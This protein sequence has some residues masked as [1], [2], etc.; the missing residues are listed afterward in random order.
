MRKRLALLGILI[1]SILCMFGCNNDPYKNMSIELVGGATTVQ[2]NIEEVTENGQTT[3]TYTPYTFDVAVKNVGDDIDRKVSLS[4]G[5]D[6]VSYSLVYMGDGIT[7]ISVTPLSY[8]KTG[9]FTLTIKTLEGNKV[10]TLDFQIDLKI[11]NFTINQDNL[12]V[13]AKGQSID[14][15][16]IDKYI[17]FF[18]QATTQ[19]NIEFEVVRPEGNVI[20]GHGE[21]NYV[22][23]DE[24]TDTYATIEN[25]VL[26]TFKNVNYPKMV[27]N[28]VVGGSETQVLTPCITLKAHSKDAYNY[29]ENG[30]II[31]QSIPDRFVDIVVIENCENIVL[32]MNCQ[33]ND[34][35]SES[36]N[37]GNSFAL[38]KNKK[39]EYDV[40]LLNPNYRSG[41]MYDSYYIERDLMFDFGSISDDGSYNP[42]DYVVTTS[43]VSEGDARPIALS[44]SSLDNSF[45]VQ[46]QKTGNYSHKFKVD[47]V[48]YPNII[49]TEI[50]VNFHVI[51]IPTDI[52]VNGTVPKD[53]YK[54]YKNYGNSWGT[55]FTVSLINGLDY[56]YFVYVKDQDLGNNL[57]FYKA[58]GSEQ[59]FGLCKEEGGNKVITSMVESSGYSNFN[60][61][62]TFYLRHNFD[63]LP[64]EG[65]QIY[66]GVLFD[67]ASSSYSD[68][69]R[70]DYFI[71]SILEFPLNISF[72]TGLQSLDFTADKYIVDLTNKNY[73][74]ET[75]D[76]TGIKLFDLPAGQTLDN[77]INLDDI[78]YD[79]SLITVYPYMD[80]VENR[81]SFYLK[82]NSEY[83]TGKTTVNFTTKNGIKKSV[84][85]ETIIPTMYAEN[86]NLMDE[87]KMPLSID[88]N[89]GEVL[90][91]FTG[92]S[93]NNPK[94]KFNIYKTGENGQEEWGGYEYTSLQR[95]FM[96]KDTSVNLKFYDYLLTDNDGIKGCT[97]IDITSNIGV[98]FNYP[99]YASY[100]NGKLSV[101]RVTE[102]INNP[103]IMTVSYNGGYIKINDDGSEE[104]VT[105]PVVQEIELYIYLALQGVQVTTA[106]SVDIYINESLGIYSKDLSKHTIRSTFVPRRVELGAQWNNLWFNADLPVSLSYDISKILSSP[107]YLS[108]GNQLIVYS[109]DGSVS[110]EITY[111][112]LF[113]STDMVNYECPIECRIGDSLDEW[114]KTESG[115]GIENYDWF[116]QNRIFNNSIVMV[117]NVYITQFS[118]LQNIN[119]VKFSV[120]Y[121][122]KI[123]NFDLDVA[124]DGVYF[125]KR[126]GKNNEMIANIAYSID[127]TDAV[128]KE[129]MLINGTNDV[130]ST[131]VNSSGI[132]TKGTIKIIGN[133]AGVEYLTAV[134]KDNI[135]S[136]NEN[137]KTYEYYN[138]KLVQ[139]FRVKVADG[140]E[141]YP[142]EI[143]NIDDY[144][145]MQND[146]HNNQYFNYILTTNL[147]LSQIAKPEITFANI[148]EG[149]EDEFNNFSL[150]GNYVYFRNNVLYSFHNSLNNLHIKKTLNNLT[151]EVNIGLFTNINQ[152][153]T[154]KNLSINNAKIEV[155]INALNGQNVNI[156]IIAGNAFNSK[157]NNCAVNG[158]IKIYNYSADTNKS[159]IN[160]GGMIGQTQEVVDIKGLPSAYLEG[161]SNN[162]YNANV[163]VDYM[164]LENELNGVQNALNNHYLNVGGVVGL[165]SGSSYST[166]ED[167]KVLPTIIGIN[168]NSSVGGV[169]GHTK[170]ANINRV[171]VYP[172]I[173][174][175][176]KAQD[177]DNEL[178]ISTFVGSG[179][180]DNTSVQ[181]IKIT[182]SKVYF[183][184]EAYKTWNNNLNVIIKTDSKL[185]FGGI[186]ANLNQN[187]AQIQYTYIRSFHSEDL[188]EEYYANIYITATNGAII[189]GV[190]GKANNNNLLINSSYFNADIMVNGSNHEGQ[191]STNNTIG[192]ILGTSAGVGA[193]SGIS[194]SY[195]IGRVVVEYTEESSIDRA[196]IKGLY[197]NVGLVG[198]VNLVTADAS[199]LSNLIKVN[200]EIKSSSVS[201]L[202]IIENV[203]GVVNSNVYYFGKSNEIIG[204]YKEGSYLVGNN[205]I[206]NSALGASFGENELGQLFKIIGYDIVMDSDNAVATSTSKWI[207]NESANMVGTL[208]FPILLDS[209]KT[210]ALYDLIPE[211]I[212]IDRIAT[213][214]PGIYDVSYTKIVN[215][216]E[217]EVPQIIAFVNKN[218]RGNNN[219]Y[220]DIALNSDKSTVSIRFDGKEIHTSFL[221]INGDMTISEDSYGSVLMLQGFKVYPVGEGIATITLTSVL[222]KTV[223]LNITIKVITGI[224][225]VELI[226]DK[227]VETIGENEF[228]KPI[229]YIDEVINVNLHNINNIDGVSY[230]STYNYGYKLEIVDTI[231]NGKISINGKDF[232]Y[233]LDANENIYI[234]NTTS[235]TIKGVEVGS[236]K[237]R[238]YP[239]VYLEGLE[240]NEEDNHYIVLDNISK[241]FEIVCLARAKSITLNKDELKIA[242]R[243]TTNFRMIVETSNINIKEIIADDGITKSYKISIF[244][245]I[246]LNIRNNKYSIIFSENIAG[247]ETPIEYDATLNAD[248]SYHISSFGFEIKH[249]LIKLQFSGINVSKTE[250]D[251]ISNQNT[252]NLT[253]DVVVTF[254]KDY[255]RQNA[256]DFDLN[257]LFYDCTFKPSSNTLLEDSIRISISP[258]VLSNIFTNYY[259]RGELLVNSENESYP[260]ENEGLF[261]IPGTAGLLKIT[262]DE[263]FNDSSYVT[264]TIDNSYKE[265]VTLSQM[266]GVTN[267]IEVKTSPDDKDIVEYIESYKD[268]RFREEIENTNNYG[269]RLSKLSLNYNELGYFSKTYFVKL[270]LTR[271]YGNLTNIPLTITSYKVDNTGIHKNL[272]KTV[273]YTITQLPLI[274]IKVDNSYSAV[275]GRGV[276]KELEVSVR[277]ITKDIDFSGLSSTMMIVD[278]TNNQVNNLS[279]DYI[280]SGRKYYI[281]ADV[282]SDL[283]SES[284]ISI[285]FKTEE[286]VWGVRETTSTNLRIQIVEYEIESID[287]ERAI[288]GVVTLKHGENLILNTNITYKDI[289]VGNPDKISEYKKLLRNGMGSGIIDLAEYASAGVT[290]VD[291]SN[292]QNVYDGKLRL[293]YGSFDGVSRVYTPMKLGNKY[294][295]ISLGEGNTKTNDEKYRLHYFII[296]GTGI[297]NN[298]NALLRLSIPYIY[299]NGKLQVTDTILGYSI[300][301]VDF[302][303]VVEDSS[304]FDRPNPIETQNDLI[305]A[306]N[307]GGGDYILLNNLELENWTPLDATFNSLDGNGYVI[308]VKS[309]NLSII[310][311]QDSANIGIFGNVSSTTL[312]KN[313][314]I[315]VSSMLITEEEMLQRLDTVSN[316]SKETYL[317]DASIDLSFVNNVTFGILAGTNEGAI[318]NAKV[319][320]STNTYSSLPS[321]KMYYHIVT[322]QGYLSNN[323]VVSKIGGLVG[324][325]AE[326]G[327][328]TNSIIGLNESTMSGNN[329]T[330][331]VVKNPSDSSYNNESDELESLNIYPFVIAGGNNIAGIVAENNGTI[332]NSYVKGVGLYNTYPAVQNSATGGLVATNTGTISSSHVES[333]NITKYRAEEDKF[334]IESTGNIGGLVYSNTGKIENAYSNVYLETQSA[335]TGGFVFTNGESGTI[336]NA[337][338]TSVN[339][340]NLARGQFTGVGANGRDVL[341]SGEYYN[342]YYLVL[343]DENVN[344]LEYAKPIQIE[345]N[346]ISNKNTWRGFSFTTVSNSEGIWVTVE[347]ST[348]RLASSTYDTNSFR[349]LTSIEEITEGGVTY[350]TYIYE[351]V[352]YNLG[353]QS[354]PLIIDKASNFATYIIDNSVEID[355]NGSKVRAFG[356]DAVLNGNSLSNLNVVRH[357]RIVNNLNFEK[358][359]T[360]TMHKGVYLYNL[361][362]AGVLDG[363]G[364]ILSNLNINTD[365]IQLDNFGLFGQV[366]IDSNITSKQTV[367]K[368]LNMNLRTYKSSDSSRAGVLA[369]TIMNSSIIN[370]KIDGNASD[371]NSIVVGGRNMAGALAGLIYADNSGTIF[372]YDIN[373]KN[374]VVEASYGSLGGEITDYS[375]D[376]S[377]GLYKQFVIKNADN[378]DVTKSFVGLYDRNTNS[379]KLFVN[380]NTYRADVS[381]AGSIAGVILANNYNK[382]ISHDNELDEFGNLNYRTQP[383]NN[384]IDNIVASGNIT[385]KTA[386]NS[387]GLFGYVGENTLIKNSKFVLN[388]NQIIRAFNY[389]GGLVA[390]NHGVIEQCYI[391]LSDSEQEIIDNNLVAR[392]NSD[393]FIQ[394][395]DSLTSTNYTVSIGGIAG[396]SSNGVIIDSYSKVNVTKPL[397]YIAGGLIGYSED[398]NY[399]AF[400]YTT[401]AVYS[402]FITGGLVG[403]QVNSD[404][405][406]ENRQKES[407][408]IYANIYTPKN[409]LSMDSVYALTDWNISTSNFD[410][411]QKI[412]EKLYENQKV[413][414]SRPD[415]TYYKFYVKM[416][417]IGNLNI[418][419]DKALYAGLHNEYYVGSAIG[420][421]MLNTITDVSKK[422]IDFVDWNDADIST[423]TRTVTVISNIKSTNDNVVTNTLGLYSTNGSLAAGNKVDNYTSSVFNYY[424]DSSNYINLYSY[425]TSYISNLNNYNLVEIDET[426]TDVYYD[427]FTYP[428]VFSQ[429]YLE[430]MIGAYYQVIDSNNVSTASVFKFD[431]NADNRFDKTIISSKKVF[432][433]MNNDYIWTLGTY[434]PKYSYGL[435][436]SGKIIKTA[437]ELQ[438][439]L[440]SVS[441]GR[442][443]KVKPSSAKYTLEL[444]NI[445]DTNKVI[446]YAQTI[447]DLF[448]GEQLNGNNPKIIIKI[449]NASGKDASSVNSLFNILNGVS[450]SNLDFEI[451]YSNVNF[452]TE[453]LYSNWGLFANSLQNVTINNCNFSITIE[454]DLTI[455]N[456]D[457]FGSIYNVKNAGLLFG[458]IINSSIVNSKFIVSAKGIEISNDK[459]ENFGILAGY[460]ENS[461]LANNRYDFTVA[462]VKN[463]VSSENI[464]IAGLVGV[465]NYSTLSGGNNPNYIKI[466]NGSTIKISNNYNVKQMNVSS[467]VA[468]SNNA[469]IKDVNFTNN[470]DFINNGYVTDE[471]NVANTIAM[472]NSSNIN[473]LVVSGNLSVDNTDDNHVNIASI[474]AHDLKSSKMTKK[475]A[476]SSVQI[477]ATVNSMNLNV[478]GLIGLEE[479]SANV[480]ALGQFT[481]S[482]SVTNNKVGTSVTNPKGDAIITPS[483]TLIGGIIGNAQGYVGL[484]NILSAG[485]IDVTTID[486]ALVHVSVGG[487]IGNTNSSQIENFT[488][489]S[490]V[491]L[492]KNYS[493]ADVN[494][495]GVIG[496]NNGVFT[497]INGFVLFEL[498][499]NTNV[500]RYAITNNSVSQNTQNVFYCNELMGNYS[501]DSMFNNYALADLYGTISLYSLLGKTMNTNSFFMS[502]NVRKINNLQVIIPNG[503]TLP[504]TLSSSI[505]TPHILSGSL[506]ETNVSG[507]NVILDNIS[508]TNLILNANSVIS[509]RTGSKRNAI[510]TLS[511]TTGSTSTKF[512]FST[513][514]GIISNVYFKVSGGGLEENTVGQNI[515]L[516]KVNNGLISQVYAYGMTESLFSIAETNANTGVILKS[517]SATIYVGNKTE[518]YGLTNSNRGY[519]SDC[520]SSNFGHTKNTSTKT[521]VYGLTNENLGRIENSAYFIPSVMEY[522]NELSGT[523]KIGYSGEGTSVVNGQ[524]YRC[525]NSATPG[526]AQSRST[527]WTSENDH[528]Q[529]I[530]F[531]DIEGA[532]VLKAKLTQGATVL[533]DLTIIRN[534][535]ATKSSNTYYFD[536]DILFY[537]DEKLSYNI[538]RFNNGG[539][540]A[541]YINSI[542]YSSIPENTI[543]IIDGD[544]SLNGDIKAIS[545][546]SSSMVVGR[547]IDGRNSRI[548]HTGSKFIEHELI[549]YNYGI[550]ACIDFQ[551]LKLNNTGDSK[552]FA[553]I[554]YNYGIVYGV[555]LTN[556]CMIYGGNSRIVAGIV[557]ISGKSAVINRCSVT[558]FTINSI[559]FYNFICNEPYGRVYNC[560]ASNMAASGTKYSGG[561]NGQGDND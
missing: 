550:I 348:P 332:S 255:Y 274:D 55:R 541:N 254:D 42:S 37:Y 380:D 202:A 221:E 488:S 470:L 426:K 451:V 512:A 476:S 233:S 153:V 7:R 163:S 169:I 326:T 412:T 349:K 242:P 34:S 473:G 551:Q 320:N 100:S 25:G 70:N 421:I 493:N 105:Y 199:K 15:N 544:I 293:G 56:T 448:I 312:I 322:S 26:K 124:Q 396:Y 72:E 315:D 93:E 139:T 261:V 438:E 276:S 485:K 280:N 162:S 333:I 3:Y 543:I 61:N 507:Y 149:K 256:N 415:G 350:N 245:S 478:G 170:Y 171:I 447:R 496:N 135:K 47:H 284:P 159:N 549:K 345:V 329:S 281:C 353:S 406:F 218:D 534:T 88:F 530:G 30:N 86:E 128:N 416:P 295:Y 440:N 299:N 279:I 22:Y 258:N 238:I 361:I 363:N 516:V 425:R 538:V 155:V 414:Y 379:T 308:S 206:I 461:S 6:L 518:I 371:T 307:A 370:V 492:N 230:D 246:Q 466:N 311:T 560:S 8:A 428:Q 269:I 126:T 229:A 362:F 122:S 395:F 240:Y 14:L 19:K 318:T 213:N 236:V 294:N 260:S 336:T 164:T 334:K 270:F 455:K 477:N 123:H 459:I 338:T 553:P 375:Y 467:L 251:A 462:E 211:K 160:I 81:I 173:N 252:Y 272:E 555:S 417:E 225:S 536:Y 433:N 144:V 168:Y 60:S 400:S 494:I 120:K 184:K 5:R 121:A 330:I 368:N 374:I 203:Y 80:Y 449:T 278:D 482:V 191:L 194:D 76:N 324:V 266:A 58:D 235:L 450:L 263:E 98:T 52:K 524:T 465:L 265:F 474:I 340:N 23:D 138:D 109:I 137:T 506:S 523:Y 129:I 439:A 195:G 117:V 454:N 107:I 193:N 513:N 187:N 110:R 556:D 504:N 517:A 347:G 386:D 115:Y 268:I 181:F 499:T 248:G 49:D 259:T 143:R 423:I 290:V 27:E 411:R 243:N 17:N 125:E 283:T 296:K 227:T 165:D 346:D 192:L 403:L 250:F 399:I 354:N 66:I 304:S 398:Y 331:Q 420:Y 424:I 108:N 302:Q 94:Y 166:F 228:K 377:N 435:Y 231:N 306:C 422:M 387:G 85:V 502:S 335:F 226:Y 67:V 219:Y 210:K 36:G 286:I 75:L 328:I 291:T 561:K 525:E 257:T 176:D 367:V 385:I 391:A 434:L 463:S 188:S 500:N 174:I 201:N 539:A 101:F 305:E 409:Y 548:I 436:T 224:T 404:I 505:Y 408:D 490:E 38:E 366:G 339:K 442:T 514:N 4:G 57:K 489:L 63:V 402:R 132:G 232:K 351:Y 223:K 214:V 441:T 11:N 275:I 515:A 208:A 216:E 141:N 323:L 112:D 531:K 390:E 222:D 114:I 102:D 542:V 180:E 119:S 113:A 1:C 130:Y 384:T 413:L 2:L 429:E 310:R 469:T 239:I 96:L 234:L 453:K 342:C 558:N 443:Y 31:S 179:G 134:P 253:F 444:N 48:N 528:A 13:V 527:I 18:P 309:F 393:N 54:V 140:S 401:G 419:E 50:V 249:E 83:K 372:M 300:I 303:I 418:S 529:I 157:I 288:D 468:Y 437:E 501:S 519:I 316:A 64:N 486:S 480:I 397:A 9:K 273:T 71:S 65:T 317:Y 297:T 116:L 150:N 546:P 154:L 197:N 148:E 373:V 289:T 247:N 241:E 325:N 497:G 557:A 388:G 495:S 152:K 378:E 509:G 175:S 95:L 39:G 172:I 189:G 559:E 200:G 62:E 74:S 355:Y 51:D 103:L 79:K 445:T 262:L 264:V 292:N 446:A 547:K 142:F 78:I 212:L 360:S 215:G 389:A 392:N 282:E 394:L 405:Q 483:K 376:K 68:Q 521:K 369:G 133:N 28:V 458:E 452:E 457:T 464:N 535:L 190:V 118:K 511:N 220:F 73:S 91:Y 487:I 136:Y 313:V 177:N 364:M 460:V 205:A 45:K 472:A 491:T 29:D 357:V 271:N 127:A 287:I 359:T 12:K 503:T 407:E 341:N 427:V 186:I 145:A 183:T 161:L 24:N 552:Y 207:W 89:E 337:Y 10:Q 90:Y 46:A 97:P 471:L 301:E 33:K 84:N 156:G 59:V 146:I 99:G 104:Y 167:L 196:V 43:P 554:M 522:E 537:S 277:G 182:N 106:K 383:D 545:V 526:F 352:G 481:G 431:Y 498:P 484:T 508:V 327:A 533:S 356:V 237:F 32:K 178:N 520:Y 158:S 41:M 532:I 430:Q 82:C 410:F 475:L 20:N 267:N 151:D 381:Y 479:Y 217:I 365:T 319:I 21:H 35:E 53:D 87:D 204:L 185:N 244:N 314:T 540:L 358:I 111:G 344:D 40:T 131:I 44:Y 321:T 298:N 432:I 69:V 456:S 343:E 510:I 209:S 285:N 382:S 198:N 77:V 147:S 16:A 92:K